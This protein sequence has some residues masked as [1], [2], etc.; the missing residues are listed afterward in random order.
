MHSLSASSE[1]RYNVWILVKQTHLAP[2]G[3]IHAY[4]TVPEK[5]RS[6]SIEK[7]VF[8]GEGLYSGVKGLGECY[9]T[10]VSYKEQILSVWHEKHRSAL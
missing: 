7:A 9:A 1:D 6:T 2:L 3:G 5:S 4:Q 10:V 8:K